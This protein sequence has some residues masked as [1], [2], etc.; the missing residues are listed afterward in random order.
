[1]FSQIR[2]RTTES[3]ETSYILGEMLSTYRTAST[4]SGGFLPAPANARVITKE[5][6]GKG[7]FDR[8]RAEIGGHLGRNPVFSNIAIRMM[9]DV[10]A[11]AKETEDTVGLLVTQMMKRLEHDVRMVLKEGDR[12][13]GSENSATRLKKAVEG[14]KARLEGVPKF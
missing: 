3:N 6:T 2:K 14:F 10:E 9:E 13:Q 4:H 11:L 8:Q 7:I 5:D 1:M 12:D